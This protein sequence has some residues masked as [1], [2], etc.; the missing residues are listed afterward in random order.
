MQKGKY[1]FCVWIYPFLALWAV[2]TRLFW[3]PFLIAGFVILV[4]KDE[5]AIKQC[6]HTLVLSLIYSTYTMIIT[7]LTQIPVDIDVG[8]MLS[9]GKAPIQWGNIFSTID[10]I[11]SI[12]FF[13]LLIFMG[14]MKLVKGENIS[15]FGMN[16]VNRA[17]GFIQ[18]TVTVTTPQP[19]NESSAQPAQAAPPQPQPVDAAPAPSQQY[20]QPVQTPVQPEPPKAPP[21][22]PV[23]QPSYTQPTP[24]AQATYT[25]P[26]APPS[27]SF[28]PPP[29]P[30]SGGF[31]PPP[32][33]P[34]GGFTPPPPP[35]AP[36]QT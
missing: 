9:S 15:F 22:A 6:L 3:I 12:A 26:P 17:Y 29:A 13:A 11:I 16:I 8:S 1:G 28:T 30:P 18:K 36:P 14:M 21:T 33:P 7:P 2:S 4:E 35:P 5:W 19:S 24:V 27:G 34:S 31:T 23:A 10:I 25:P 32:P 20:T